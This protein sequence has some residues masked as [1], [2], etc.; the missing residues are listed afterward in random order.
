[1]AVLDTIH[2]TAATVCTMNPPQIVLD[3]AEKVTL[4]ENGDSNIDAVRLHFIV[5]I[6]MTNQ[7]LCSS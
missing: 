7:L 4:A 3:G 2:G 6:D 1:M 5:S